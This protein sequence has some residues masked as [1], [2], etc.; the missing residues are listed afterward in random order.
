MKWTST[1]SVQILALGSKMVPPKGIMGLPYRYDENSKRIIT[2]EI[3]K[4]RA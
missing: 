3:I 1:K 4:D 2:F